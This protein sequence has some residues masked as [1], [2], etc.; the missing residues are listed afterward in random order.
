MRISPRN[1]AVRY[2][3][4]HGWRLLLSFGVGVFLAQSA[5]AHEKYQIDT[6]LQ[7]DADG[8][9]VQHRMVW[10]DIVEGLPM[11]DEGGEV[12]GLERDLPRIRGH[13][14]TRFRLFGAQ[15]ELQLRWLGARKY[16]DV[17]LVSQR[18]DGVTALSGP[19]QV[20]HALLGEAFPLQINQLYCKRCGGGD[21]LSLVFTA[22][23]LFLQDVN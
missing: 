1:R 11:L 17:L 20:W 3:S 10:H 6:L 9:M 22:N 12:V 16:G 5:A 18:L 21:E 15:G 23:N 8:L 4:G 13:I 19:M 2:L 7:G 14:E